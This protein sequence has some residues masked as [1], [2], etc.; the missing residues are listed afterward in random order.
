MAEIHRLLQRQLKRHLG[1]GLGLPSEWQ[2][3]VDEVDEAYHGFEADRAMLEQALELSS[4]ELF[5]AN[6]EMRAVFQAIPDLMLRLNH[7]VTVLD[8]KAGAAGELP[9]ARQDLLGK[10]LEDT[11]LSDVAPQF[12]AAVGRVIAESA[13]VIIEYSTVRQGKD[14]DYEARLVPLRDKEIVVIIRDITERK[15]ALR[16]VAAAALREREE[17]FHGLAEAM[18]QMVWITQPDGWNVYFNQQWMDYTGL[19]LEESMGHGWKRPFHPEDRQRAWVMW[20]HA[21]ATIGI[22]S[23]ECRLRRVDGAYRWWLVRGVPQLDAN[24]IILK[25]FG[26]CTDIH[27]LKLAEEKLQRSEALLRIAGRTAQLGGWAV[28]LPGGHITWSEGVDA[29]FGLPIG[30]V[31]AL[32]PALNSVARQSRAAIGRAF[33]ACGQKGTAFDLELKVIITKE[34]G[35]WVRCTGEARRDA[36]GAITGVQGAFQDITARKLAELELERAHTQLVAV[37]RQ[38]GMAEFATGILH[39]VGNVLNSVNIA[40][41][42]VA[43]SLRRSKAAS[44]SK[45]VELLREHENDLGAFFTRNPKGRLVPDFLAQLAEQL[46][47]EQAGALKELAELQKNIEHI[48]DIVTSQ[49][50][51][52]KSSSLAQAVN[53]TQLVEDAVKMNLTE[54]ALHKINVIKAC[55]DLPPVRLEKSRILQILVNLVRNAKQACAASG[56]PEKKLTIRTTAGIGCVRI[57]VTDNGVGIPA[58]NLAKIFTHGFTTKQDGHGFGLNSAALAAKEMGGSLS[59][60]SD[61]PGRGAT[62]VLELPLNAENSSPDIGTPRLTAQT[63]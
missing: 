23:I 36:T 28:D 49:Q 4:Q 34:R 45:V 8:V 1:A 5:E 9:L 33:A 14:S 57:A 30:A 39:N 32:G 7:Q 21:V 53:V 19:T 18:P 29:I 25:W 3:F 17:E 11:P 41:T 47:G 40:S 58:E 46:A 61:G 37:S 27:E 44:L 31:A 60:Q 12:A 51:M 16:L 15:Q 52:A 13:P 10:R 6:A 26:T 43:D 59:V 55:A 2:A 54:V 56:Q 50:G 20:Q 24:G 38:A 42:C 48:K 62:F 63:T 35:R 22:Y